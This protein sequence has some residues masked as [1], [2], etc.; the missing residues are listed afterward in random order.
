M[1]RPLEPGLRSDYNYYE[2]TFSNVGGL[3]SPLILEMEYEDWSTRVTRI[4]AEIWRRNNARVSKVFPSK[5][6]LVRV[7]LDPNRETADIDISNNFWPAQA[8][9]TRFQLFKQSQ[10][11]ENP[12]QRDRRNRDKGNKETSPNGQ[13]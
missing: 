10:D 13:P 5:Q 3:V 7:T 4:P 12:M 1:R 6:K 11:D 8:V 2:M 9:P